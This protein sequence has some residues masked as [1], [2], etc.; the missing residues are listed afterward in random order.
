MPRPQA[1]QPRLVAPAMYQVAA[2]PAGSHDICGTVSAIPKVEALQELDNSLALLKKEVLE[3]IARDL[4]IVAMHGRSHR[5][6]SAEPV[7]ALGALQEL[8][9]SLALLQREVLASIARDLEALPTLLANKPAA[10]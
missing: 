7:H 9:H 1:V 10:T 4:E 2:M 5:V 6:H 3:S 8:D